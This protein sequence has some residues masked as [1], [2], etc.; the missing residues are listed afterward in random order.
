MFWRGPNLNIGAD[1]IRSKCKVTEIILRTKKLKNR[2][3]WKPVKNILI[4]LQTML[5]RSLSA[6][7]TAKILQEP[8][9]IRLIKNYFATYGEKKYINQQTLPNNNVRGTDGQYDYIER[10]EILD[11]WA[12]NISDYLAAKK[13]T[14]PNYRSEGNGYSFSDLYE[15]YKSYIDYDIPQ[16]YSLILEQEVTGDKET[17]IKKYQSDISTYELDLQNMEEKINDLNDLI[18]KYSDKN[19]EG[20]EYHYGTQSDEGNDASDYILKNVYDEW[21]Q[22]DGHV[23]SET[24]YDTLINEYVDIETEKEKLEVDLEHKKKLLAVFTD[25]AQSDDMS[26]KDEIEQS[27]EELSQ[28]AW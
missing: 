1:A 28:K 21:N 23:Q 5:C 7:S 11:A 2:L 27:L 18:T 4:S 15:I 22:E 12:L 10:V 16:I 20:V 14:Q 13:E 6:V 24:T 26:N 25:G 19:K 9:L 8:C 17:L 3:F